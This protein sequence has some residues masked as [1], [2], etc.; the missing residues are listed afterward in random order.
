MKVERCGEDTQP[1]HND[2]IAD[3]ERQHLVARLHRLLVW[4]G[5]PLP[6]TVNIDGK[7]LEIHEIVWQCIH[8]EDVT[9]EEKS[10][11]AEIVRLLEKKEKDCEYVLQTASLTH[12]EAEKLYHEIASIIRAIID[13]R[14]CETGK[15]D[16]KVSNEC[17]R[18]RVDDT[19]RWISFLKTVEKR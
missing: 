16:L 14:E 4:V 10:N 13:I 11:L 2:Y 3:E 7:I 12:E 19:K 6:D 8:D 5:E 18:Q 9:E 17:I 15:V 1:R